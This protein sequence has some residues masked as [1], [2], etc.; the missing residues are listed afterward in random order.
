MQNP[1]H[2]LNNFFVVKS[3]RIR[4]KGKSEYLTFRRWH[5]KSLAQMTE[6]IVW[7]ERMSIVILKFWL[8]S[9]A[10]YQWFVERRILDACHDQPLDL[11]PSQFLFFFQF[12]SRV[13][14]FNTPCDI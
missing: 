12:T 8:F 2:I 10:Q 1:R 4:Y 14:H 5:S 13:Q 6:D 7:K 3:E 11:L 9:G